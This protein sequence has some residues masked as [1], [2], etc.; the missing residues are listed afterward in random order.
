MEGAKKR[1][2]GSPEDLQERRTRQRRE[3]QVV[4]DREERP[5]S[6][7]EVHDLVKETLPRLGLATVYR[8]INR[9]VEEGQLVALEIPGLGTCYEIPRTKPHHAHFLCTSCKRVFELEKE[10]DEPRSGL[11]EGFVL[12]DYEIILKGKCAECEGD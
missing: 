4:F 9:L 1:I 11:P 12:E 10:E 2:S 7:R 3:I 8:S 6:P 5:L